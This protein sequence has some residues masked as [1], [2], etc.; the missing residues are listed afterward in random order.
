MRVDTRPLSKLLKALADPTRLRI[1]AL[2]AHG[3]LCVCHL[4]KGLGLLQTTASRH[5]GV[6]RAAGVVEAR[7]EKSW[8][9]YRLASQRDALGKRVMGELVGGFAQKG[10]LR[11]DVAKLVKA[12][13]PGS[14]R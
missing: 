4:E 11:R 9:Y 13:G 1:V 8:V 2:L 12:M 14:C 3:E 7:R 10:A 5:L 6:L